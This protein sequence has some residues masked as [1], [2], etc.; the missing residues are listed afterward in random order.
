AREI[1]QVIPCER[2]VIG[3]FDR[4]RN[5]NRY[6]HVE[7]EIEIPDYEIPGERDNFWYGDVID[8]Q[9]PVNFPDI[10]EID[11]PR[12]KEMA[13]AGFRSYFTVPILQDDRYIAHISLLSTETDR[14]TPDQIELLTSVTGYLSPAIRNAGLYQAAEERAS[15][16]AVLNDLNQKITEN[17]NLNEVLE[18]ISRAT[19]D[20]LK[21]DVSRI[22][23]YDEASESLR[24]GTSEGDEDITHDKQ[25]N[26]RIG[27]G[28][29]GKMIQTGEP[30]IVGDVQA[31]PDWVNLRWAR[32]LGL[33]SY[34]GLPLRRRE[35]TI[36]TI[37]CLSKRKNIFV[38]E[39]LDL[40]RAFAAQAVVAIDNALLHEEAQRNRKF[41]ESVVTD[42]ADPIII[43]D[44]NRTS[45]LWNSGAESLYGYAKEEVLGRHVDMII[46]EKD[47]EETYRIN[48]EMLEEGIPVTVEVE[49]V[50]KDG[51]VIPVSMTL[52][53][54]RREDGTLIANAGIHRDLTERH[55]AEEA[56]RQSEEKFRSLVEFAADTIFV[57]DS[58]GKLLDVNQRACESL[59]Y[60][61]EELL[62]LSV[63]DI[64][65]TFE[66][67]RHFE[68]WKAMKLDEPLTLEGA[69]RR[70]D[71]TEFP[72]EVRLGKFV[73]DGRELFVGLIRD[74]T[75]HK[76]AEDRV[77]RAMGEAE[78]ASRA[79]SEFLSNMSHELRSPLNSVVGFS[80]LLI[81]D[82]DDEM[83]LRLAPKI[84]ES[85]EYLAKLIEDL[86]D[87]D[88]I[89]SGN[90]KLDKEDV[91]INDL[92]KN[93]V[94]ARAPQL[95]EGHSLEIHL[96]PSCG[97]L[98]CDPTRISQVLI[99]LLDNAVKYSPGGGA[100]HIRTDARP[101]EIWISI[102]DNGL[103]M[104]PEELEVIF[105]RFRQLE[106]GYMRRSGGLG[107]G[108]SLIRE[109]VGLHDGRIWVE[110]EKGK[111]SIFTFALPR[112]LPGGPGMGSMDA[113][114]RD[115]KSGAAASPWD[116]I[117]VLIMDDLEHYHIYMRLLMSGA[118]RVLSAYN[119][120]EGVETAV[121]EQPDLILV[122]LRMPVM[123]GFEAIENLRGNPL[124]REIPTLAVTAQ[125]MEEDRG[126]SL[127]AGA[128]GF[129]TKPIDID[130][131]KKEVAR[132]LD[133]RS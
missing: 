76:E 59:G 102:K 110:S 40:L 83:T 82:S 99:N 4:E 106:S 112:A 91:S 54:V 7:S 3:S 113:D 81:R 30:I 117:S 23:L 115:A 43:V 105:E 92:V 61:R 18:S 46:P 5:Q 128:D 89:E 114:S 121:R 41:L 10:R 103:G 124:T 130:A 129:V 119:G 12:M 21:A 50:S 29:I 88:R 69:H 72:V 111:G 38:Q 47:R 16:L 87:F 65:A 122:D 85:G 133:K 66:S 56:L 68:K 75:E 31:D 63:Q 24:L 51:R 35:K 2:F 25:N 108:L 27:E 116:K 120:V 74:M 49:R 78:A 104:S 22:F 42:S 109:L 53:P 71:G 26:F 58:S 33:H 80:D 118:E 37:T 100:I 48:R 127:K 64:E 15:R 73:L 9:R 95:T 97:T 28:I 90:V 70:K 52:S 17:L 93:V 86:L 14:F 1:R 123:D 32:R 6:W 8:L 62:A 55:R 94:E 67:G 20:L 98:S 84:K 11:T 57:H 79:K 77:L 96:N 131:L 13:E 44:P 60:T 107:I 34:I 126:R 39:D 101:D 125:V 36:G 45:I 132:I 19:G